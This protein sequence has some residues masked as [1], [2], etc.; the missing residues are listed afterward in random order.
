M[1]CQRESAN[2]A[3]SVV[4]ILSFSLFFFPAFEVRLLLLSD[5][6]KALLRRKDLPVFHVSSAF[7]G[8]ICV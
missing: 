5:Q 2:S 6:T 8:A 4:R 3:V 7:K 1:S